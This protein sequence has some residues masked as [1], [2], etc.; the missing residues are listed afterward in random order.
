LFRTGDFFEDIARRL[1]RDEGLGIGTGTARDRQ[2]AAYRVAAEKGG[3]GNPLQLSKVHW[4]K[5]SPIAREMR[6]VGGYIGGYCRIAARP[7]AATRRKLEGQRLKPYRLFRFD[8]RAS[9]TNRHERRARI[10][11]IRRLEAS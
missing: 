6:E 11:H 3:F 5:P 9:S 10:R 8:T 7:K 4:V 2:A 1:G